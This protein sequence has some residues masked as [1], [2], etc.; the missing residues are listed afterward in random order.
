[1][2]FFSLSS[3]KASQ[4]CAQDAQR[5]MSVKVER[6]L[7]SRVRLMREQRVGREAAARTEQLQ[8]AG[9]VCPVLREKPS[10]V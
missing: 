8:R 9:G 4:C 10:R 7:C 2:G 5:A 3:K 6:L 1:M